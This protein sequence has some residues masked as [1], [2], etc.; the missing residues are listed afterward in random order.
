MGRSGLYVP[1]DVNFS[2]DDKVLACSAEAQLVYLR[3]LMLS[4]RLD[5]DGFVHENHLARLCEYF[6]YADIDPADLSRELTKAGLWEP[7][8]N[9]WIVPS[10]AAHNPDNEKLDSRRMTDAER[11]KAWRERRKATS[12][13]RDADATGHATNVPQD[14]TSRDEM[15]HSHSK[16]EKSV[17]TVE[18]SDVATRRGASRVRDELFE[19]LAE[20]CGIDWTKIPDG[21]RGALNSAVKQLRPLNPSPA[22]IVQRAQNYRSHFADAALTPSALA[23]HWGKCEHPPPAKQRPAPPALDFLRAQ[24]NGATIIDV[25]GELR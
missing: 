15:S 6:S 1:L 10:W 23:R 17:V 11:K 2:D 12:Q 14:A 18:K 16:E 8:D 21:E 22:E 19:T 25:V 3:G 7:V 9:G 4:K 24:R 5:S 20:V 13:A